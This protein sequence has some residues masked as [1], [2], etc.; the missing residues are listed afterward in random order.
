MVLA[1][2]SLFGPV[3]LFF[4]IIRLLIGVSY[5]KGTSMYPTLENY[6][7]MLVD[8]MLANIR[9]RPFMRNEIV[10]LYRPKIQVGENEI[11]AA[12]VVKRIVAIEGDAVEIFD[13]DLYINLVKQEESFTAEGAKYRIPLMRVADGHVLVLGD[14]RIRCR[15]VFKL[16]PFGPLQ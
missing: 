2:F 16:K 5:C 13:G 4:G 8:G 6:S 1:M 10:C 12:R 14:N 15:V 3:G 7:F 11:P 9:P